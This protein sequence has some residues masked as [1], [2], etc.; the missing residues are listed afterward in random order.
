[1]PHLPVITDMFRCTFNWYG[2]QEN[3]HN[4][5]YI[6]CAS[7]LASDVGPAVA[8][9]LHSAQFGPISQ[10]FSLN[11]M[12][13][14]PLDGSSSTTR[15]SFSSPMT[16]GSG[17]TAWDPALSAILTLQ[18]GV[19]GSANRGRLYLGPSNAAVFS[20]GSYTS[21]L[22]ALASAWTSWQSSLNAHTPVCAHHQVSLKN[23]THHVITN[24][25][26]QPVAGQQLRRLKRLR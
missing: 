21:S 13:V 26:P 20:G 3:Y 8:A 12:D 15:Y 7:G 23:G 16:G 18:T 19:R 10:T 17:S 25:R 9:S 11:D 5:L 1:V 4:V 22:S 14:L 6:Q 2:A 24:Y